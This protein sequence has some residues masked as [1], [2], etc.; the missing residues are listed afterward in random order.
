VLKTQSALF[1]IPKDASLPWGKVMYPKDVIRLLKKNGYEIKSGRGSHF[2]VYWNG[3]L[4]TTIPVHNKEIPKGLYFG[5]IKK[6]KTMKETKHNLFW[7]IYPETEG[8]YWATLNGFEPILTSGDTKEELERMMIDV[9]EG[10]LPEL[11]VA[12]PDIQVAEFF[13]LPKFEQEKSLA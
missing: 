1:G 11:K 8:G 7:K 6:L 2:N 13:T 10:C 9:V 3:N 4:I 12:F 5:I